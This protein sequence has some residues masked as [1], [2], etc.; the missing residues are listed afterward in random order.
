MGNGGVTARIG[1]RVSDYQD[2]AR[3]LLGNGL[4]VSNTYVSSYNGIYGILDH[5]SLHVYSGY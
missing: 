5:W 4:I 2:R 1:I 3:V